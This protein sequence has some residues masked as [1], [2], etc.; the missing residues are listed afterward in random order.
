MS[1]STASGCI[2]EAVLL[3][4][5]FGNDEIRKDARHA[6]FAVFRSMSIFKFMTYN[7]AVTATELASASRSSY[8]TPSI[9]SL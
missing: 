9:L 4:K 5:C 1:F 2:I 6:D 8:Y 3:N 7:S